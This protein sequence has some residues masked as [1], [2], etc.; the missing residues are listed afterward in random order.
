MKG[1]AIGS[2][3]IAAVALFG[4]FL[5]SIALVQQQMGVAPSDTILATGINIASPIIF[6]GL[7]IGGAIPWLFS[8]LMINAVAKAA[9]LM[10]E[11]VRR[12]FKIPGLMEG[13]EN[14]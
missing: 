12:Q 11:E 9:G 8:A 4:S 7:L 14:S 3:V 6:V 5:T 1:V 2:A 10:V 13:K